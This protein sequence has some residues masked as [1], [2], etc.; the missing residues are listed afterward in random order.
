MKL[1]FLASKDVALEKL[2]FQCVPPEA[3]TPREET[4]FSLHSLEKEIDQFRPKEA[5]EE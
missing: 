2:P 5:E 1:G 4:S 3:A